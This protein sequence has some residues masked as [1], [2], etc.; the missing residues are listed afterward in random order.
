MSS[1]P[2]SPTAVL[3]GWPFLK[4]CFLCVMEHL[5]LLSPSNLEAE[6]RFFA[7]SSFA[8]V[9]Q[10]GVLITSLVVTLRILF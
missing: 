7:P 6:G 2:V 8:R 9:L 3:F 1:L 10:L 5:G 4:L